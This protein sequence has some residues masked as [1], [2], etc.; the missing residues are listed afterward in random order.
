[1]TITSEKNGALNSIVTINLKK[2]DIEGKV[3]AALKKLSK[4]VAIKGFR[5][6]Q[7]PAPVVK[8]MYGNSVLAEEINRELND[9]MWKYV[10]ENKL[11]ILG[12]PIP[13]KEQPLLDMDINAVKD[14]N[15]Q[16]ELGHAP[17][18]ELN[19]IDQLPAFTRYKIEVT[20]A[21]VDDEVNRLRKRHSTYEYP[22]DVQKDDILSFTIE[23]L[24]EAGNIR[25][26]GISTVSSVMPD[27]VKEK[28]QSDFFVMKKHGSMDRDIYDLFDRERE[29]VAKHVLNL[30]D[31]A[32]AD[33]AGNKFRLTLNNIT[34][35]V[36]AEL[37]DEF[38][39]KAYGE[40]G[41]NNETDMRENIRTELEAYLD[42]RA[43]A[44]LVNELYKGVLDAASF[45]LPDEFL[46]RWVKL[47][48]E[49]PLTDEQIDSDYPAFSRQ[50]RWQLITNKV[51]SQENYQIT[52]EE[53]KE[54]TRMQL[55]QQLYQ[56][57]MRNFGEDWMEGFVEKQLA[58]KE[59]VRRLNEEIMTDKILM[60]I[61]SRVKLTDTSIGFDAFKTMV[62]AQQ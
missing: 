59:H 62:E 61:K 35:A 49:K 27:M 17:D 52:L 3:N 29:H 24:D 31:I 4:Q 51:A 2:E 48:N 22:E 6:G 37:N 33:E 42:G 44:L 15:F 8:K 30:S 58:D 43:D 9:Q 14:I 36:T 18:F 34:R 32:K 54:R 39:K 16:Y 23:E 10:E 40:N 45:P 53:I 12:Q 50:L 55:M 26:G 1:M 57:G 7:V 19:F 38:F 46:K 21:M 13:A 28:Y 25:E 5:P 47:S 20:D 60:Y 56:Y 11:N 41:I